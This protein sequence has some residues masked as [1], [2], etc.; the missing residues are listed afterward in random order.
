MAGATIIRF[1]SWA[2]PGPPTPSFFPE[3]PKTVSERLHGRGVEACSLGF[4]GRNSQLL[5]SELR[6]KFPT[7]LLYGLYGEKTPDK[8]ILMTGVNDEIQHVGASTYVEYTKKLADYFSEVNNVEVISIPR[9]NERRF[10]SPNLYSRI[11][12]HILKCLNDNCEYQANDAYRMALWRDHPELHMIEYDNFIDQYD[13]HEQC[14]TDDGVH[15]TDECYHKYG[16]FI[17]N[18]T[19]IRNNIAQRQ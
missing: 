8:V 19:S 7:E 1:L 16:T 3:L 18:A 11:K 5:Y 15:L 4:S 13:G 6:E 10:K 12:R 17:G 9:V 2:N 14:Y